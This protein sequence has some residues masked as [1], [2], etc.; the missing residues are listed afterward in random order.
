MI[1]SLFN[2]I[3]PTSTLHQMDY[4][5]LENLILPKILS[6]ISKLTCCCKV[7]MRLFNKNINKRNKNKDAFLR[8]NTSY[9]QNCLMCFVGGTSNHWQQQKRKNSLILP[10]H[11]KQL[12]I[13]LSW[14]IVENKKLPVLWTSTDMQQNQKGFLLT[15]QI[16]LYIA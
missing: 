12:W 3:Y 7:C 10:S 8:R 15:G 13:K 14:R 11:K 5:I 2:N 4:S 9:Q 1:F 6:I 16:T